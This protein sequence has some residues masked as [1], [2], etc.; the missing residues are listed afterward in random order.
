MERNEQKAVLVLIVLL[1]CCACLCG[2]LVEDALHMT[3]V[4]Q[5]GRQ[6]VEEDDDVVLLEKVLRRGGTALPG[7][8]VID[9]TNGVLLEWDGRAAGRD[10]RNQSVG[11]K[12]E[13]E[14]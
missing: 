12:Y 5:C 7:A 11:L 6:S 10:E 9:E 1:E 14:C 3:L 13:S 2:R 4:G 8:E